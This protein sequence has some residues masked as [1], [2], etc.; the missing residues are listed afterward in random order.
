MQAL[1]MS[2]Q[3]RQRASSETGGHD[4]VERARLGRHN[5]LNGPRVQ[6]RAGGKPLT[7]AAELHL[8]PFRGQQL[9]RMRHGAASN[10]READ[11]EIE[12]IQQRPQARASPCWQW[13]LLSRASQ[14]LDGEEVKVVEAH[15]GLDDT[16]VCIVIVVVRVAIVMMS[17]AVVPVG[18]AMAIVMVF[19]RVAVVFVR[20]FVVVVRLA[21]VGASRVVP[22]WLAVVIHA[23][24]AR[25]GPRGPP[26]VAVLAIPAFAGAVEHMV[27]LFN[28][29][30]PWGEVLG[31]EKADYAQL[32]DDR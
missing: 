22:N 31:I 24:V 6:L 2:P 19:V 29:L 18:R 27:V 9:P 8:R 7:L 28:L 30:K 10:T 15:H 25:V 11:W 20:V 4:V 5:P 13:R 16:E 21:V 12:S 3:W 26:I 32:G 14:D 23:V 17:R 1:L